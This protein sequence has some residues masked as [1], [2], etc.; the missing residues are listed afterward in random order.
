MNEQVMDPLARM[1]PQR[2]RK[3]DTP[4]PVTYAPALSGRGDGVSWRLVAFVAA[5]SAVAAVV[6]ATAAALLA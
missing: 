4:A 3:A 2:G 6:C 1:K 5:A